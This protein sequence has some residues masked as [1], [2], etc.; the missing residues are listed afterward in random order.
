M[1]NQSLA[2]ASADSHF[3]IWN[4]AWVAALTGFILL[5]KFLPGGTRV[6]RVAGFA[7]IAFGAVGLI[8]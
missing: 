7:M 2:F 6:A 1:S 4:L 3:W 8:G 5:E